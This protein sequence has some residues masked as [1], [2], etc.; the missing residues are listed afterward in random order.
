VHKGGEIAGIVNSKDRASDRQL[1]EGV[2][3]APV[4]QRPIN[5]P[6]SAVLTAEVESVLAPI[7]MREG[8][9]VAL[10]STRV[11]RVVDQESPVA[12]L[13]RPCS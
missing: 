7:A 9:R 13:D 4:R 3:V 11:E 6:Q 5:R 12:F 8:E 1:H 10:A 2:G